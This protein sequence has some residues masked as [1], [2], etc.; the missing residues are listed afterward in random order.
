MELASSNRELRHEITQRKA[1]EAALK[2]S[3]LHYTQLLEQSNRLQGQL[4]LLSREILS[5]QE[6]ERRKISRELHDVIAQTLTGINLPARD[7]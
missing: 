6:D 7:P 3:E 2:K 4:R 5:A 1:V